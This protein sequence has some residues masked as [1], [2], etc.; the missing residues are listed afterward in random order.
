[1]VSR[2]ATLTIF[3]ITVAPKICGI[4]TNDPRVGVYNS[5]LRVY[6]ES[7]SRSAMGEEHV[8]EL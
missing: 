6:A 3:N 7:N 5:R 1:M 8:G 4:R 2:E